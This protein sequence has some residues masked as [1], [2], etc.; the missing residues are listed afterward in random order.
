MKPKLITSFLILFLIL[1]SCN[2]GKK[3]SPEQTATDAVKK[4][5]WAIVIHGGAGGMTRENITPEIDKNTGN[6]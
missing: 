1:L 5:E 4:Q 3:A 6:R 2:T